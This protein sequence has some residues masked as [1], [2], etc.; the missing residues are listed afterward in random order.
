MK[1]IAAHYIVESNTRTVRKHMIVLDATGCVESIVPLTHE[2][3]STRFFNG[4]IFRTNQAITPSIN[5]ILDWQNT[6]KQKT[7]CEFLTE[8]GAE[9]IVIGT[10]I[11]QLYVLVDI[12]FIHK[13]ATSNS[14]ITKVFS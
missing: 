9:E 14:T 10:H 8:Y 1:R 7:I 6:H 3:P 12:D 13:R 5:T 4:I 2:T 11:S